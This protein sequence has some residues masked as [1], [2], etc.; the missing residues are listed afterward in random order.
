MLNQF[1]DE[2]SK[3]I[4][5]LQGWLDQFFLLLPNIVVAILILVIFHFLTQFLRKVLSTSMMRMSKNRTI[6]E[7]VISMVSLVLFSIGF[8]IALEI[9]QLYKLVTSLLA[10]VGIVGLAVGLAFRDVA[11]N[12]MAGIYLAIKSPINEDDLIEYDDKY[13]T[14]KKIGLRAITLE[15]LQG[16][17]IVIPNRYIIENIYKHFTIN[18]YRRVD[19]EVG[20]SYGDDL[21][22]AEKVTLDAIKKI[23]YLLHNKPIDL[24]YTEFG[25]SSINFIIRYWV[26][27]G[28]EKDY[29]RALSD[30]IKNIKRAYDANGITITFPIR[31][32]DFGIKGGKTLSEMLN[33]TNQKQ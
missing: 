19:L 15:T 27:F 9:L 13:G 29:L 3:V 31:T 8:F 11:A 14:V 2:L 18:S 1:N 5:K 21:E 12:F 4:D 10:G 7:F 30:G 25:E 24:F 20:I 16:Q 26:R 32:L 22:N 23:D 33:E 28:K 17:D 6:N